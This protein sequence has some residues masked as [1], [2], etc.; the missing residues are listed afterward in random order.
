[1]RALQGPAIVALALAGL[2]MAFQAL[3]VEA[4]ICFGLLFV[5]MPDPK[6]P[7]HLKGLV[8]SVPDLLFHGLL[9]A[10]CLVVAMALWRRQVRS[11]IPTSPP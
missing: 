7:G 6:R 5:D 1:M 9:A 4:P 3:A 10:A 11:A 2:A 8:I